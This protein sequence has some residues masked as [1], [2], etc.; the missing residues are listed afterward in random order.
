MRF[1]RPTHPAFALP[2]L[3]VCTLVALG[4]PGERLKTR[5][6]RLGLAALIPVLVAV[7]WATVPHSK[8]GVFTTGSKLKTNLLLW[9]LHAYRE[10]HD[11][12][13]T[14]LR[15]TT[16]EV[17]E[18]V[19]DDPMP[20]GSWPWEYPVRV[21]KA[22]PKM[23]LSEEQNIPRVLK[24][25]VIVATPGGFIAFIATL[26]IVARRKPQYPVEWRFAVVVAASALSLVLTYSMLVFDARY[27]YPLIPLVLA[28]AA[29]F[30]VPDS[31][32]NHDGWRKVCIALVVLGIITSMVYPSSP[33][34]LLTRDFQASCYDAGDRLR[35]HA[36]S[37]V[38]SIGSG[39]YPAHGVG[40]EAGY[41]ASFF[42]DRKIIGAMDSL[43]ESKQLSSLTI[44]IQ[45]ASPG[46]I[47][48]WGRSDDTRY[49]GLIQSLI[50]QY[51]NH[52]SEK[53]VDPAL[54]EVGVVLFTAR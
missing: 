46:A 3:G 37:S 6:A 15:D 29:R 12:T 18:Y 38:V 32:F 52:S 5:V 7:G 22:L 33:F 28:V 30:L 11:T 24:E 50:L 17:D 1:H 40:W 43:P 25:M 31:Q 9:T 48:V 51:P 44:D 35:G 34:R 53:I 27:L 21:K 41:K 8:Y 45:K 26:A 4:S 36:G 10:H 2:W 42:G 19:V 14:L 47:L 13:Y 23:I 20:P 16:K 49:T 54:G 39:P